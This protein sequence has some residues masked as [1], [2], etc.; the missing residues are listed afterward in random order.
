MKLVEKWLE[1]CWYNKK[2]VTARDLGVITHYG[3]SFHD[4]SICQ[5]HVSRSILLSA[6]ATSSRAV[7]I[8]KTVLHVFILS[9][10]DYC[11]SLLHGISD[12]LLLHH[13]ICQTIASSLPPPGTVSF[14][15][16]TISCALSLVPVHI[17]DSEHWLLPDYAFGT[18]FLR[19]S[20]DLVCPWIPSATNWK[21][22]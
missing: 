18:V 12:I 17:L 8:A 19:M 6:P 13:Y 3:P 10:W 22:I 11:N 4:V 15:H 5:V 16:Q 1:N 14:Y 21:R 9:H 7:L 20:V 2:T